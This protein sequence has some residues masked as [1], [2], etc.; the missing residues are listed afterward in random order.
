MICAPR[1]GRCELARQLTRAALWAVRAA[2]DEQRGTN[3]DYNGASKEG[4]VRTEPPSAASP[5]HRAAIST[6]QKP[7][8]PAHRNA[9][10]HPS[11]DP[12][13]QPLHRRGL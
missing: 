6:H 1:V 5:K 13:R 9:G 12:G 3:P 4:I 11:R 10:P 8:E 2:A 7:A